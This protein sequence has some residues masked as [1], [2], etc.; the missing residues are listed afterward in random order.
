M[1]DL[2]SLNYFLGLEVS[3][4]LDGYL[5]SQAKYAFDLLIRLGITASMIASTPLD[6]NVH[7]TSFDGVPPDDASLYW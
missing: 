4:C 7:L 1:K 5:L 2:G 6:P 3:I